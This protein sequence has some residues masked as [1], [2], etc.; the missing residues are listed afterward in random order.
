M[1]PPWMVPVHEANDGDAEDDDDD[2]SL[3]G[4]SE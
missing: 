3:E 1:R 2:G 4:K